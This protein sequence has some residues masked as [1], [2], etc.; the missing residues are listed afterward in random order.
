M[1]ETAEIIF[2]TSREGTRIIRVPSP[3]PLVNQTALNTVVNRF[4]S[5]DPFNES[6]G[7]L[8]SLLRADRVNVNE[9][10]LI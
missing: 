7:N 5:A 8:I 1:R 6:V 9:I 3:L 2:N 10:V 4:M